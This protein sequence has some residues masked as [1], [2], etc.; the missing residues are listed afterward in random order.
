MLRAFI[1]PLF[2]GVSCRSVRRW[3]LPAGDSTRR[4]LLIDMTLDQAGLTV[5]IPC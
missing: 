1:R 4:L 3:S 2:F 5:H